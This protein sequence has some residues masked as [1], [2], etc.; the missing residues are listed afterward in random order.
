MNQPAAAIRVQPVS[1]IDL[2]SGEEL[3][4][5]HAGPRTFIHAV[6]EEIHD[7]TGIKMNQQRILFEGSRLDDADKVGVDVFRTKQPELQF[8]EIS[9]AMAAAEDARRAVMERIDRVTK[10]KDLDDVYKA[11][12]EVVLYAVE[13]V[14]PSELQFADAALKSNR[15]VMVK[16]MAINTL[17]KY[18][19]ADE[20]WLDYAFM[21]SI[22][23]IDGLL[24][25]SPQVPEKWRSDH[26]IVREACGN[27]GFALQFASEDLKNDRPIVLEAVCERGVALKFASDELK[28]DY[29]V[30]LEAVRNNRMAIVHCKGGLRDDD[31]L[32]AAA[33]QG[34]SQKLKSDKIKSKFRELDTNGDG[35]LSYEE[36]E[37]MLL[38]GNPDMTEAEVR[39]L[40][41][42]LDTHKDGKVDFHEFCDFV[43]DLSS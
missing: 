7:I 16:A 10:L 43:H 36:L 37:A 22:V 42:Q 21:L 25:G 31:D 14:N 12:P 24:L 41:D 13:H 27:H 34:P 11:D 20:L 29:D 9:R 18:Y 39:L 3:C 19:V 33:G 35:Y 26:R 17:S 4:Q 40:Y 8:K 38:S 30:A 6:K 28:S 5:V 1:I 2:D 15:S 23:N 32:R